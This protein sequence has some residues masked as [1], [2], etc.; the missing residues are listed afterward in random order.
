MFA[1]IKNLALTAISFLRSDMAPPNVSAESRQQLLNLNHLASSKFYMVF[2]SVLILAFF[3]F[4]SIGLMFCIPQLPEFV[5]AFVTMFT[6]TLEIL[7]IIISTFLGAQAVVDLKYN[8][9]S[10]AS[11]EG[12]ASVVQEN[13]TVIH[14]NAKEDDYELA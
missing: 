7:A 9:A 3:Y 14:T 12:Y 11:I 6:K 8:S 13:I 10:S 5:T 4:G 1:N 2:V